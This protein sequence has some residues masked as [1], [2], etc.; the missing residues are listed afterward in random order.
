MLFRSRAEVLLDEAESLAV[1]V[2]S[3]LWEGWCVLEAVR[4]GTAPARDRPHLLDR[5]ATLAATSGSV[6]LARAVERAGECA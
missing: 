2:G 3:A 6:R 5:A 4:L 1:R